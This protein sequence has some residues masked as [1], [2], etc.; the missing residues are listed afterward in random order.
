[1]PKDLRLFLNVGLLKERLYCVVGE[2]LK[3]SRLSRN[4]FGDV[5]YLLMAS[6]ITLGQ[7]VFC[8]L[9]VYTLG[10][11]VNLKLP[12]KRH[13]LGARLLQHLL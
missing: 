13:F 4:S 3:D 5:T 6:K 11:L 9:S 10:F 12:H 2:V 1:M 8:R 7:M